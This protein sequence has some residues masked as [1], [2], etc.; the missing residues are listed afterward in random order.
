ME[1]LQRTKSGLDSRINLSGPF[2]ACDE[3]LDLSRSFWASQTQAIV[4]YERFS[5][6][7][8]RP[9]ETLLVLGEFVAA[10]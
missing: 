6:L 8:G 7:A 5:V 1:T 2:V 4:Q 3:C 9:H 10:L